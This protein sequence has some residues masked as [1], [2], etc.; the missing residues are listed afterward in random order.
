[1]MI[2]RDELDIWEVDRTPVS[3]A[4]HRTPAAGAVRIGPVYTPP[5]HRS[6]GYARGLVA[7][8]SLAALRRREMRRCILFTDT[9]NP[10]SNSIYRQ[11]GYV[12]TGEHVD[13]AFG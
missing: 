8:T 13:I 11:I 9:A 5:E 6:H 10:V 4:G 7:E 3:L 1:M 2:E 12:P